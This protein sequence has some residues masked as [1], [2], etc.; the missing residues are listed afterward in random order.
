MRVL[1]M[2][3]VGLLACSLSLAQSSKPMTNQ[4]VINMVKAKVPESA[5]LTA[6]DEAKPGFDTS[7]NG[8][9]KLTTAGVPEN[10]IQAMQNRKAAGASGGSGGSSGGSSSGAGGDFNPEEVI[11]TDGGQ[12]SSMKYLSPTLRSAARGL[13]F[14]GVAS[15]SVLNGPKAALRLKSP[16]PSFLVAIPSNAQPESYFNLVSMAVRKNQSREVLIGGGYMSYSTGVA[17]DRVVATTATKAASQSRA[18]KNFVLYEVKVGA[19]LKPGEYAF[20]LYN[21]QVKAAGFFMSGMD[22]YFD[23][24]VD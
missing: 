21:S 6:I 15:Y 23:F 13:G 17:R 12:K 1:A 2:F 11:L 8:L 18:P 7:A 16:E 22:S 24:G 20:V 19:P 5:I 14:G 9:I 3:A 4:D 10:I